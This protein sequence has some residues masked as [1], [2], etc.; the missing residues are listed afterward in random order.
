[1][2]PIKRALSRASYAGPDASL[3]LPSGAL[4]KVLGQRIFPPKFHEEDGSFWSPVVSLR[5]EV[6]DDG[7]TQGQADGKQFDDKFELKLNEDLYPELQIESDKELRSAHISQFTPTQREFLLDEGS[8]LVREYSKLDSLLQ[9]LYGPE[10]TNGQLSFNL[11][12]LADAKFLARVQPRT[13]QRP[14]SYCVWDSFISPRR[15]KKKKTAET[16]PTKGN[17]SDAQGLSD[18]KLKEMDA[19]FGDGAIA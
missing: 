13:G 8:W 2:K 6:V 1:L 16:L 12:D 15:T 18:E 4:L 5:L 9:C 10:W 7:T 19:A 14:G 11:A 3:T 17:Q